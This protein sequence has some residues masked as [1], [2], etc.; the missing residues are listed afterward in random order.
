[1]RNW[2]KKHQNFITHK[3]FVMAVSTLMT[4]FLHRFHPEWMQII[5]DAGTF[6]GVVLLVMDKENK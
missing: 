4:F 6:C 5:I 2:Y 1:M 3:A